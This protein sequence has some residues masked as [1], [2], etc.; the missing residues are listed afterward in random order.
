[1]M[2]MRSLGCS[3]LV[4]AV[5]VLH[6]G[7]AAQSRPYTVNVKLQDRPISVSIKGKAN[8]GVIGK[9]GLDSVLQIFGHGWIGVMIGKIW[10]RIGE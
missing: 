2:H 1:M 8:I 10:I 4:L 7:A 5:S 3:T 9:D 6:A